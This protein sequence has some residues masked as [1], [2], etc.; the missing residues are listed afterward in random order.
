MKQVNIRE[1]K[2]NLSKYLKDL[3]VEITNHGVPVAWLVDVGEEKE[4]PTQFR[5]EYPADFIGEIEPK[6]KINL[7]SGPVKPKFKID[8]VSASCNPDVDAKDFVS[9]AVEQKKKLPFNGGPCFHKA[10]PG[11]CRIDWC[12]NYGKSK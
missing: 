2:A 6:T 3:P 5:K 7:V 8:Y 12:P 10:L 11:M 9:S 1:L 4:K